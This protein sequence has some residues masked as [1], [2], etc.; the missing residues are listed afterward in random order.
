MFECLNVKFM[1]LNRCLRVKAL[2]GAYIREKT[3]VA[4]R[5]LLRSLC[6]FD[7]D[8]KIGEPS[9]SSSNLVTSD[10]PRLTTAAYQTCFLIRSLELH[11]TM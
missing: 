1:C 4:I 2:V 5:F 10:Y 6:T 8:V 7:I 11:T 3:V 9:D